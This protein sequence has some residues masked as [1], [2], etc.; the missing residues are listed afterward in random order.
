MAGFTEDQR[1]TKTVSLNAGRMHRTPKTIRPIL[2]L[3]TGEQ[4]ADSGKR[5]R[6]I[7]AEHIA[8]RLTGSLPSGVVR[9]F[10]CPRNRPDFFTYAGFILEIHHMRKDQF[11]CRPKRLISRETGFAV[12]SSVY[13][14]VIRQLTD[15]ECRHSGVTS[16]CQSPEQCASCTLMASRNRD[17]RHRL[18][19]L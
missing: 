10:I 16:V 3:G 8:F 17:F 11:I 7:R 1:N 6:P 2:C 19:T 13:R 15:N 14:T 9:K 5:K 4:N 18:G 12:T